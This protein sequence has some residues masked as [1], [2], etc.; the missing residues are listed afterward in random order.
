MDLDAAIEWYVDRFGPNNSA[1]AARKARQGREVLEF[2]QLAVWLIGLDDG[3][4]WFSAS[5]YQTVGHECPLDDDEIWPGE[6]V[7]AWSGEDPCGGELI[8]FRGEDYATSQDPQ[9]D[10]PEVWQRAN[11]SNGHQIAYSNDQFGL[12]FATDEDGV[13]RRYRTRELCG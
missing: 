13:W 7:D 6:P 5:T 10:P 3:T 11:Y 8:H 2:D 9:R 1:V 4:S 12:I